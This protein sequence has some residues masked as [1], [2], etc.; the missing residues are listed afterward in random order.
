HDGARIVLKILRPGIR[1]VVAADLDILRTLS[2]LAEAHFADLGYSPTEVVNEFAREIGKELDLTHEGRSTDRLR[3][4]FDDDDA[5]VFPKVY[6][7]ATT[8]SVLALEEIRGKLL[9]RLKAEEIPAE[10]RRC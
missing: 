3:G 10:E 6:W 7:E 2:E 4:Y 9:S 1:E 8:R 5:V